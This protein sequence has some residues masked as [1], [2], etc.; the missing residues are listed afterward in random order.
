MPY[1]K[2]CQAEKAAS[3]NQVGGNFRWQAA[4]FDNTALRSHFT[5]KCFV[6][7]SI[8]SQQVRMKEEKEILEHFAGVVSVFFLWLL[9]PSPLFFCLLSNALFF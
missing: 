6:F 2:K 9:R 7:C 3:T 4:A 8:S 1:L 5:F